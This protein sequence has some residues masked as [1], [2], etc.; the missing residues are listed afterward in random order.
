MEISRKELGRRL[1]V[2]RAA[3]GIPSLEELG[4][5]VGMS[6]STL[7]GYEKGKTW[8]PIPKL[9]LLA[10][11]YGIPLADL[12]SSDGDSPMRVW[13]NPELLVPAA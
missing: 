6:M 4:L 7:S 13:S 11:F 1:R 8:P 9:Q 10:A 5:K 12:L 3:A 2:L